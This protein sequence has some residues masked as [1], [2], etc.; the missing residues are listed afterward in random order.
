MYV[1]ALSRNVLPELETTNEAI[2][3]DPEVMTLNVE[4]NC[5]KKIPR[6]AKKPLMVMVWL[7]D[8]WSIQTRQERT[9]FRGTVRFKVEEGR[10]DGQIETF[11]WLE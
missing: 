1:I 2:R 5:R 8:D 3:M 7:E 4:M 6:N 9:V 11:I 10:W